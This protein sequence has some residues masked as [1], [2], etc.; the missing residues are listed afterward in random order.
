MTLSVSF[1][2]SE[3]IYVSHWTP[4]YDTKQPHDQQWNWQHQ[5]HHWLCHPVQCSDQVSRAPSRP[6]FLNPAGYEEVHLWSHPHPFPQHQ[7]SL[8]LGPK[9]ASFLWH[10]NTGAHDIIRH[11]KWSCHVKHSNRYC[12]L[13]HYGDHLDEIDK[14]R[15]SRKHVG[16]GGCLMVKW[17]SNGNEP[18]TDP[19]IPSGL[20]LRPLLC[21]KAASEP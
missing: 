8:S 20:T 2:L 9:G 18:S 15:E 10:C 17:W 13:H 21:Q 14:I 16:E 19:I 1:S 5:S 7:N 6:S 3:D 11:L 4:L 12:W